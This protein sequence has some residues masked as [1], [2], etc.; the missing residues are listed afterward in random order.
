MDGHHKLI[1][2]R[3]VTHAAVD[4][5][6]RTIVYIQCTGN[7]KSDTVLQHFLAGVQRF[8]LPQRVRSDH[9]GENIQVW[10]YMISSH[11]G[12]TS[13]VITGSSTHN[14]RIE[15]LWRDVHRCVTTRFS[16][17]FRSL[18]AEGNLDA[19]NEVD[20]FCLHYV[21]LPRL[22]KALSEFQ[23]SWNNH[24][25]STEGSKTPYQLFYEGISYQIQNSTGHLNAADMPSVPIDIQSNDPVRVPRNCFKPCPILSSLLFSVNPLSS[26]TDHGK[27]LF[28]EAIRICGQH[29]SCGCSNCT[30][31]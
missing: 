10:R 20:L 23:E 28:R 4:G 30:N 26:A 18:E 17:I 16:D 3:F 8:G 19:L 1:R 7:N 21:Y 6:S 31:Q 15:R 14:E 9:G 25:L 29:L 2:W 5:F 11:N 22:C 24:Q 13:R 12:D 27:E